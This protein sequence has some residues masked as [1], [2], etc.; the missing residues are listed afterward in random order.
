MNSA[1]QVPENKAE[2]EEVY[3]CVCN[4]QKKERKK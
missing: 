3:Y 2:D 4:L 1:G